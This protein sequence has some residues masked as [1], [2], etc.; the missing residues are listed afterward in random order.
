MKLDELDELYQT[1]IPDALLRALKVK[2]PKGILKLAKI[3]VKD[4]SSCKSRLFGIL[5]YFSQ[6][7]LY[8]VHRGLF[9]ILKQIPSDMT[10]DQT[11]DLA[12]LRP[13]KGSSFH[14]I[15]L[16]AATD[17]FPV[18]LQK[19]VMAQLIGDEKA[20]AWESLL[21]DRDYY[22]K[23]KPLRYAVGQPMGAYSS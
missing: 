4:D 6:T 13:D 7:V 14:S 8:P 18:K 3:S 16:T 10:F 23:G 11:K 2:I 1:S 5:D 15:D 12:K 22:L 19:M 21:I 17:R 9:D 20:E